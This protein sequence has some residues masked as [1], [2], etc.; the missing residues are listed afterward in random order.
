MDWGKQ[1]GGLKSRH[2]KALGVFEQRKEIRQNLSPE[3]VPPVRLQGNAV[4]RLLRTAYPP[5]SGG[6]MAR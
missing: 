4:H 3:K 5:L 1:N 6:M 2:F